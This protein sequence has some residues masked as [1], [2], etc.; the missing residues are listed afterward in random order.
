MTYNDIVSAIRLSREQR[1]EKIREL[2]TRGLK[3][4]QEVYHALQQMGVD[5]S[6]PTVYADFH[7]LGLPVGKPGRRKS[8]PPEN[9]NKPIVIQ[10][11]PGTRVVI[12][13]EPAGE[14]LEG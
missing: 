2:F 8:R 6:R 13:V 10:V 7:A 9:E 3:T 11:T 14:N 5:I 12:V 1:R 4:P